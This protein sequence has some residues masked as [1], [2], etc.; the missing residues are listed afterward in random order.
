MWGAILV[1]YFFC[2]AKKFLQN[3]LGWVGLVVCANTRLPLVS[4][5]V[6]FLNASRL[7][8]RLPLVSLRKCK[9]HLYLC[10]FK[11]ALF[12]FKSAKKCLREAGFKT[13]KKPRVLK[14]RVFS[15]EI[16]LMKNLVFYDSHILRDL[17]VRPNFASKICRRNRTNVVRW[18][19]SGPRP[20]APNYSPPKKRTFRF[21]SIKVHSFLT[22]KC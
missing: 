1:L 20:S 21:Y 17:I 4:L 8:T 9:N 6:V 7:K 13:A 2:F 22:K 3:F 12:V 19:W 16:F 10:T 5:R 14:P 15:C 11:S 18:G